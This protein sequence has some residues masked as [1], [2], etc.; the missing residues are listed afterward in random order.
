[1]R[2]NKSV[3]N[4]KR[5]ATGL[6]LQVGRYL[7]ELISGFGQSYLRP[8]Y[9]M[10]VFSVVCFGL[11]YCYEH[12]TPYAIYSPENNIIQSISNVANVA[13]KAVLP[14]SRFLKG[15]MEFVSLIFYIIYAS[16]IWQTIVAVKSHTR[17]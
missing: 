13:S 11:D 1:M 7:N 9:L 15:G 17:R 5:P 10:V 8:V 2:F 6:L 3:E 16:L 4:Y 12:N 14:I